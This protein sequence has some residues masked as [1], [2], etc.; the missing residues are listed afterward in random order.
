M[1]LLDEAIEYFRTAAADPCFPRHACRCPA[2]GVEKLIEQARAARKAEL[3]RF[4]GLFATASPR[5]TAPPGS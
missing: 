2:P 5:S 3:E 1:A 4:R